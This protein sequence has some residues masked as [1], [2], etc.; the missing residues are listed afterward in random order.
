[1]TE[2]G[3]NRNGG[4]IGWRS[5]L[6]CTQSQHVT[7][8]LIGGRIQESLTHCRCIWQATNSRRCQ[9]RQPHS[10][11]DANRGFLSQ[12]LQVCSAPTQTSREARSSYHCAARQQRWVE[13]AHGHRRAAAALAR[14][15]AGYE[16][17]SPSYG[18]TAGH[19][20]LLVAAHPIRHRP[21][22]RRGNRR[23]SMQ[24]HSRGSL[25]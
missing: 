6:I 16:D 15:R 21:S 13:Y 9:R 20:S 25:G 19:V 23:P 2:N 1:M 3:I 11:K 10:D 17:E 5:P 8:A 14:Y 4:T 18:G 24:A 22:S 7:K 12:R